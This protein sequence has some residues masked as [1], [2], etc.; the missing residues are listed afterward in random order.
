[1]S[2]VTA[3]L[4]SIVIEAAVAL[5]L[6]AALRWPGALRAAAAA[7]LATLLSHPFAWVGAKALIGPLGYAPAVIAVEAMVI[8]LE[9]TVYRWLVPLPWRRALLVS[10]AANLAS[11]ACGLLAYAVLA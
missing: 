9:S 2:Q 7:A 8:V 6:M 10:A 5:L 4:A 11:T 1:M 3:M